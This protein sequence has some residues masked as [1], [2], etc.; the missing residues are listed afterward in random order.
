MSGDLDYGFENLVIYDISKTITLL[1]MPHTPFENEYSGHAIHAVRWLG[2]Q[3]AII[4][5]TRNFTNIKPANALQ[6]S[7][8]LYIG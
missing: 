1:N 4:Q 2:N 6:S 5:S 7:S 3:L 8:G